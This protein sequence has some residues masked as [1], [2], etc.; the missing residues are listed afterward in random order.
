MTPDYISHIQPWSEIRV[1]WRDAYSPSSGWHE[2]DEYEAEE[3][4]AITLGRYWPEFQE[5]Y[6]TMVGTV[7]E[8]E[9]DTPKTVG[10]I[11]HIPYGWILKVETLGGSNGNQENPH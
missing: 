4:Q 11:N 8:Y 9:G 5:H 1:T 3:A 6:L 10:D 2:V 7:F